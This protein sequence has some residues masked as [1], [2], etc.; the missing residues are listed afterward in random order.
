M[1]TLNVLIRAYSLITNKI[2]SSFNM[3]LIGGINNSNQLELLIGVIDSPHNSML[4]LLV[5]LFVNDNFVHTNIITK[6]FD[7]SKHFCVSFSRG[8]NKTQFFHFSDLL[9]LHDLLRREDLRNNWF[10]KRL[11]LSTMFLSILRKVFQ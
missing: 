8:C 1:M 2:T 11:K 10:E 5:I 9:L 6:E 3:V 7:I 4:K